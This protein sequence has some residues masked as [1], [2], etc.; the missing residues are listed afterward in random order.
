MDLDKNKRYIEG[1]KRVIES[2]KA[3]HH[4]DH[5]AMNYEYIARLYLDCNRIEDSNATYMEAVIYFVKVEWFNDAMR[6]LRIL[7][8]TA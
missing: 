7:G 6:I 4:Y 3:S 8:G 1:W 2:D 5:A